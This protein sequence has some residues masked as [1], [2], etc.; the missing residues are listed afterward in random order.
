MKTIKA[1]KSIKK[2]EKETES[3]LQKEV[4]KIVLNHIVN[5]D[6]TEAFFSDLMYGGCQS[7]LIGELIYYTDTHAFYDRHS[8]EIDALKDDY[9][10]DTGDT[11]R[12][13][14]DVRNFL[15]WFAFERVA[16]ELE[17]KIGA[18]I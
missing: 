2:I 8:D 14:G 10:N 15:A 6:D 3:K 17:G 4:C 5:Y 7:G 11:L 18:I 12:I 13:N 9:E 16:L 1:I